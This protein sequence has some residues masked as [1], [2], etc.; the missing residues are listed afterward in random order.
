MAATPPRVGVSDFVTF[1]VLDELIRTFVDHG[2]LTGH[3]AASMLD[4]VIANVRAMNVD[5]GGKAIPVLE[6]MRDEYRKPTGCPEREQSDW[7]DHWPT[8]EASGGG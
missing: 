8:A 1:A 3:E 2:D 4:R 6:R 5:A 7:A